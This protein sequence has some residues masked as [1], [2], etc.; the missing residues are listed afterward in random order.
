MRFIGKAYTYY[1]EPASESLQKQDGKDSKSRYNYFMTESSFLR[2]FLQNPRKYVAMTF[3][4]TKTGLIDGKRPPRITWRYHAVQDIAARVASVLPNGV[5]KRMLLAGNDVDVR[6]LAY[7]LTAEKYHIPAHVLNGD[8]MTRNVFLLLPKNDTD[9]PAVVKFFPMHAKTKS[10]AFA[11]KRT[12]IASHDFYRSLFPELPHLV[13]PEKVRIVSLRKNGRPD[14][15]SEQPYVSIMCD[16]RCENEA[17]QVR[18]EHV[19]TAA[20][21]QTQTEFIQFVTE[22]TRLFERGICIDLLGKNNVTLAGDGSAP[23]IRIVD[24]YGVFIGLEDT[25]RP[26]E[27]PEH[28]HVID[29]P[30]WRRNNL[31]K[32][33]EILTR[34]QNIQQSLM[35]KLES[36]PQ[37]PPQLQ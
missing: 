19:L 33:E 18:L 4:A 10:E 30:E 14:V 8:G 1:D 37:D 23:S 24:T 15:L 17:E 28:V 2:R 35:Q 7:R 9:A 13:T 6:S 20:P 3:D 22:V 12:L 26:P 16:I 21:H 25:K 32:Y 11:I 27:I 31:K 36:R 5:R 34:L 29:T